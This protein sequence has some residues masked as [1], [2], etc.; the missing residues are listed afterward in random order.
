MT[1]NAAGIALGLF[2]TH[3][4]VFWGGFFI[5]AMFAVARKADADVQPAHGHEHLM[6]VEP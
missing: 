4:V 2:L 6:E 5:C 3:F 1:I